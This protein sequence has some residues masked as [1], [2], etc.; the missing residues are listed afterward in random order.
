MELVEYRVWEAENSI[1]MAWLINSVD[2]K[3]GWLYFFYQTAKEIWVAVRDMYSDLENIS[4]SLEVRSKLRNIRQGTLSVTE[5]FNNLSKLWQEIDMFH[6][7]SWK[8]ADDWVL[9]SKMPEKVRIFDFL[10]NQ[11]LDDVWEQILGTKPFPPLK[12]VFAEIRREETRRKVMSLPLA[13]YNSRS[14]SVRI[15]FGDK[16][17]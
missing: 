2:H 9:C 13:K 6:N 11:D 3:I 7:I 12:E 8:C 15:C 17:K 16:P 14:S 5:Y 1:V 4:Q 10:Q